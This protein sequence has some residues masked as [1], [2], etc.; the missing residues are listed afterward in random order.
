MIS[1]R[2]L[3]WVRANS[4]APDSGFTVKPLRIRRY[5][6]SAKLFSQKQAFTPAIGTAVPDRRRVSSQALSLATQQ[7]RTGT[8]YILIRAEALA[9]RAQDTFSEGEKGNN[10]T[11]STWSTRPGAACIVGSTVE[12]IQFNNCYRRSVDVASSCR[13][14][15]IASASRICKRLARCGV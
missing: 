9:S 1:Q 5:H 15:Q 12:P 14:M 11:C 8:T 7:L 3:T 10:N 6:N 13:R 4:C 2:L